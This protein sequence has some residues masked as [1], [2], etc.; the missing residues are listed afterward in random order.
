MQATSGRMVLLTAS[1]ALALTIA[2]AGCGGTS[3]T[4]TS[5]TVYSTPAGTT[6]TP[7]AGAPD[8]TRYGYM[9]I[10]GQDIQPGAAATVTAGNFVFEIPANAFAAPVKFE[11]LGA[12]AG[13]YSGKVRDGE[14]PV[15][16]FAL[17]VTDQNSGKL[18]G[19]FQNPVMM[20]ASSSRIT[21]GSACYDV[22][23]AGDIAANTTGM[24]VKEGELDHPVSGANVAW[25]ITSPAAGAAGSPRG[26]STGG[27]YPY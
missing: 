18:I 10:G 14:T 17:R 5:P 23:A 21:P 13:I 16:A 9:V 4:A 7:T 19:Q 27:S 8:W 1:A 15:L 12:D 11:V 6:G 22:T 26:T 24:Q 20:I 3:T 25:V 2:L